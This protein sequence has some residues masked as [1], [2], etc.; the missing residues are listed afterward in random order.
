[1]TVENKFFFLA[2][3]KSYSST[4]S[5][6]LSFAADFRTQILTILRIKFNNKM[7]NIS[8]RKDYL[9]LIFLI[10]RTLNKFLSEWFLCFRAYSI[11]TE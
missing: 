5:E 3:F 7:N 11:V 2:T 10:L 8:I 9:C 4:R 6:Q 1:M